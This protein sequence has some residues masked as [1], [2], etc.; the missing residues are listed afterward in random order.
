MY[1]SGDK[2]YSSGDKLARLHMYSSGDT[3][4]RL[5]TMSRGYD[6]KRKTEF[7]ERNRISSHKTTP[8]GPI[9]SKRKIDNP[10]QNIKCR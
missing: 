7:K 9:V 6:L 4:A 3:L 1:S 2:L 5:H 8:L 10:Q